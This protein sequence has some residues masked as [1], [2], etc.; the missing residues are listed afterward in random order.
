MQQRP[1]ESSDASTACF[2]E[3]E[4]RRQEDLRKHKEATAAAQRAQRAQQEQEQQQRAAA[5]PAQPP[6]DAQDSASA[7]RVAPG[8]AADAESA[9]NAVRAAEVDCTHASCTPGQHFTHLNQ[10]CD[11]CRPGCAMSLHMHRPDNGVPAA[12]P[13]EHFLAPRASLQRVGRCYSKN[14]MGQGCVKFWLQAEAKGLIKDDSQKKERRRVDKFI[15]LQV[16]QISATQQQVGCEHSPHAVYSASPDG[17]ELL[18]RCSSHCY[19][20]ISR[21]Y[22]HGAAQA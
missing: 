10:L 8:A 6:R 12:C 11:A 9:Q 22:M 5:T 14:L 20:G 4:E 3:E 1:Q 2:Q 19:S 16:Q 18:N 21:V 17:S 15:T 7:I 13:E